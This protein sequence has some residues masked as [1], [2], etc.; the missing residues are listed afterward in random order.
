MTVSKI[1]KGLIVV[2]SACVIDMPI[3]FAM[4][5]AVEVY[6]PKQPSKFAKM[7]QELK[8]S[9]LERAQIIQDTDRELAEFFSEL[10]QYDELDAN[11][12]GIVPQAHEKR[13]EV[14]KRTRS[15]VNNANRVLSTIVQAM[16]RA[17]IGS[18]EVIFT[19]E[20]A[21]NLG[22]NMEELADNQMYLAEDQEELIKEL[23]GAKKEVKKDMK[24]MNDLRQGLVRM[25]SSTMK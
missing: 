7:T 25:I 11:L 3:S 9:E 8:G 20:E 13:M 19:V 18:L 21:L 17:E 16:K 2:S 24:K 14:I 15:V 1:L 23:K 12:T 5:K 10:Q 22:T 4:E 6:R